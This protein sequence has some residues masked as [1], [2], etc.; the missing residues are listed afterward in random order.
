MLMWSTAVHSHW[1]SCYNKLC[2]LHAEVMLAGRVS[3]A[4][5]VYAFGITLWELYTARLAYDTTLIALLGHQVTVEN[6]RPSFPADT[7]VEY[8]QLAERCWQAQIELR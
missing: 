2:L 8:K 4:A 1:S 6:V 7:P 3:K 5:D